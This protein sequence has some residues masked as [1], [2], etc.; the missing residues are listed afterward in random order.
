MHVRSYVRVCSQLCT[1]VHVARVRVEVC[2][3]VHVH[4]CA[5]PAG[6][7]EL[8]E[9]LPRPG[10]QLWLSSPSTSTRSLRNLLPDSSALAGRRRGPQATGVLRLRL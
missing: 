3:H 1:C 10:D 5:L 8:S 4:V 7:A 6:N 2:G 9:A